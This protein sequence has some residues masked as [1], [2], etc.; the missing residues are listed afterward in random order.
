MFMHDLILIG[1][2]LVA[3]LVA[4]GFLVYKFGPKAAA[5]VTAIE[6][7]APAPSTPAATGGSGGKVQSD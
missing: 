7:P 6:T 4:G 2:G 5:V 1:A 3:G